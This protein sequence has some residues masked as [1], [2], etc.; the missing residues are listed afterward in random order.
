MP[1]PLSI[2]VYCSASDAVP[3]PYFAEATELGRLIARHGHSLVYGGCRVGLMGTV[4]RS[5]IENGGRVCGV[6]PEAIHARGLSLDEC[7]ELVVTPDMPVRKTTMEDRADA[8]IALPGG[9]GTL[10]EMFQVINLKQLQYHI[11]PVVLINTE[12]FYDK[13]LEFIDHLYEHRFARPELKHLYHVAPHASAAL[14]YLHA[15]TP[16]GEVVGKWFEKQG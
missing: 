2:A 15:Y 10:E 12:G 6:I 11:K 3:D 1:E 16:P 14:D 9:A 13:L 8:F 4:A 5:V 7:H